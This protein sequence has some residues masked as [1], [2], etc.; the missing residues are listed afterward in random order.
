[1]SEE[2]AEN[3]RQTIK[4]QLDDEM[5]WAAPRNDIKI[6]DFH[7]T[8]EKGQNK[9]HNYPHRG[10]DTSKLQHRH[11]STST[12]SLQKRIYSLHSQAP[13]LPPKG[14]K[15]CTLYSSQNSNSSQIPY[16]RLHLFSWPPQNSASIW[17]VCQSVTGS[18]QS[19]A[20]DP[21]VLPSGVRFNLPPIT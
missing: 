10:Y 8:T 5:R 7:R 2:R 11:K 6:C 3:I 13:P 18:C 15:T 4:S 20:R 16:N 9:L 1:M 14:K 12:K 19:V 17:Q 21:T